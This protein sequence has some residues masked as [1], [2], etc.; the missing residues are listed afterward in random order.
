MRLI[1]AEAKQVGVVSLREALRLA[2]EQ[3]LDLAEVSPSANPPVVKILDWGKYRYEQEKQAAK[4]RKNQKTIDIKQVRLGLKTNKHDIEVKKRAALKFLE[5][6]HKVKVNLRFRGREIT[7]PELGR[8]VLEAFYSDLAD[9][10]DR[11]QAI[12]QTGRELSMI[13]TRKKDAKD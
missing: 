11:E 7:H 9:K 13:I 4:S 5:K 8:E 1:D 2:E 6:G 12:S 10:A 3:G